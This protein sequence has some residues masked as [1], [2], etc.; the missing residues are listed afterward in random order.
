MNSCYDPW[1]GDGKGCIRVGGPF[2]SY[3]IALHIAI[4][5]ERATRLKT[6]VIPDY[7]WIWP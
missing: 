5:H 2:M 7:L 1:W 3:K 4:I 6:Y